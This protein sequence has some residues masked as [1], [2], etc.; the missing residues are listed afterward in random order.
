MPG[1]ENPDGEECPCCH[2]KEK[3]KTTNWIFRNIVQDFKNYGG[4]VPGYFWLLAYYGFCVLLVFLVQSVY[5]IYCIEVACS[6][7]TKE[8][9]VCLSV[10]RVFKLMPVEVTMQVLRDNHRYTEATLLQLSLFLTFVILLVVNF[11]AHYFLNSI[12]KKITRKKNVLSR[13][14]LFFKDIDR[15][16]NLDAVT[17]RLKE[18]KL[19]VDIREI[20][21]LYRTADCEEALTALLD[22][23]FRMKY[24]ELNNK[25]AEF[26]KEMPVY[27]TAYEKYRELERKVREPTGRAIIV[28]EHF[29]QKE[30]FKKL[31]HKNN[32]VKFCHNV[33]KLWRRS[34]WNTQM[35]ADKMHEP[36]EI[37]WKYAGESSVAKTKVRIWTTLISLAYLLLCYGVLAAPLLKANDAKEVSVGMIWNVVVGCILFV[38]SLTYRIIMQKLAL[39]RRPNTFL[40]KSKFVVFTTVM[41]HMLFYLYIPAIFYTETHITYSKTLKLRTL[42]FQVFIFLLFSFLIAVAD[43]KYRVFAARRRKYLSQ[44][45]ESHRVCQKKLHDILTFPSFPIE[46]KLMILYKLWSFIAFYSFQLPIIMVFLL[47][48]MLILYWNDK[49]SIYTHYKMQTYLPLE[50]EQGFQEYYIYLFMITVM[51]SYMSVATTPWEFYGAIPLTAVF[52]GLKLGL[53]WLERSRQRQKE[54]TAKSESLEDVIKDIQSNPVPHDYAS[55]IRLSVSSYL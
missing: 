44:V 34:G 19:A 12:E 18:E 3:L 5:H 42:F 43:V 52:M 14:S 9:G 20:F 29:E 8:E 25:S 31:Y 55:E 21:S 37:M 23:Y 32:L 27:M 11:A 49:H 45:S 51:L 47:L 24:Y 17:A 41:F 4:G 39:V 40:S 16:T 10:F 1:K 48:L 7:V 2:R 28:F 22:S 26:R 36:G 13:F 30:F 54:Q 35:F 46:F 50:L 53:D 15:A 38:L 6:L 33:A